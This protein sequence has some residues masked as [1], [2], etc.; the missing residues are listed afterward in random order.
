MEALPVAFLCTQAL[1]DFVKVMIL[2]LYFVLFLAKGV[3]GQSLLLYTATD[4]YISPV[5]C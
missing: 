5:G 2:F 1:L 4:M 3:N